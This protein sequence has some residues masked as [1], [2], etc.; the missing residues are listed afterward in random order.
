MLFTKEELKNVLIF[1]EVGTRSVSAEKNLQES[2]AIQNIGLQLMQKIHDAHATAL[3]QAST[4]AQTST[5]A[6]EV[7]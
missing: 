7:E 2:A 3:T 5:P 6:P 1:I 4:P